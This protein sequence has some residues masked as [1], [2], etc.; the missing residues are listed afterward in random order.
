MAP[1]KALAVTRRPL[2]T[3]AQQKLNILGENARNIMPLAGKRKA[4]ASPV[5]NEKTVKRAAL[6]N[7]TNAVLNAI[8][9]DKNQSNRSKA[10]VTKQTVLDTLNDENVKTALLHAV[11]Q[12]VRPA[13]V[14]TRAST[15]KTAM[16][17]VVESTKNATT[18]SRKAKSTNNKAN[19]KLDT[20]KEEIQAKERRHSNRLSFGSTSIDRE[21]SHYVSALDDL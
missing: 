16:P 5:R 15:R 2:A 21:D 14:A 12:A 11:S 7:V 8:D 9:N 6:G 18:A 19:L 17:M 1:A 3:R 13:K 20:V 4:D 10:A